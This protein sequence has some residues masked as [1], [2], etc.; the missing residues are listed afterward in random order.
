M[1]SD[2]AAHKPEELPSSSQA[3]FSLWLIHK[4]I[5]SD[6]HRDIDHYSQ[7]DPLQDPR[8]DPLLHLPCVGRIQTDWM[9]FWAALRGS[10]YRVPHCL[11]RGLVSARWQRQPR[12]STRI[13]SKA[14]TTIA[15]QALTARPMYRPR[16]W[17]G[18]SSSASHRRMPR[19]TRLRCELSSPEARHVVVPS[20]GSDGFGRPQSEPAVLRFVHSLRLSELS[21]QRRSL[22]QSEVRRDAVARHNLEQAVAKESLWAAPSRLVQE[23]GDTGGP[24]GSGPGRESRVDVPASYF[25]GDGRRSPRH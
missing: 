17:G 24:V 5:H 6:I 10:H 9:S 14:E 16:A 18:A 4:V 2:Q 12:G 19:R 7:P 3:G 25:E 22:V 13:S 15:T 11:R 20:F 23:P 8:L 1:E 21:T